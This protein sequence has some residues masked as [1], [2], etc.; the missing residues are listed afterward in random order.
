ME[1]SS[2]NPA[3]VAAV[4]SSFPFLALYHPVLVSGRMELSSSVYDGLS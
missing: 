4:H 2:R 1:P 3:S